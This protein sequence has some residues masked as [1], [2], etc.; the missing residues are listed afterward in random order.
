M[1]IEITPI[2]N[3]IPLLL[4]T[5][6]NKIEEGRKLDHSIDIKDTNGQQIKKSLNER[7]ENLNKSSIK[8]ATTIFKVTVGLSESNPDAYKPKLLSI[9]PYHKHDSKLGS[10]ENYKLC[11]LQRFLKRN[12]GFHDVESCISEMDKLKDDA[13]K[14]YDDIGGLIDICNIVEIFSE[15]LLLDGCFVVEFIREQCKIIPTGEDMIIMRDCIRNQLKRDLLLVENQLPWFVLTKLY[16][17]SKEENEKPFIAMVNRTFSLAKSS[18][19][20]KD[21][22]E[23]VKHLFHVVHMFMSFGPSKKIIPSEFRNIPTIR[24]LCGGWRGG[25]KDED[26]MWHKIM[27]NATELFE[28]GVSFANVGNIFMRSLEK[29]K[30][31]NLKDNTCLFDIKFN[32]G[33]MTIPC[34][35]VVD[36]TE[37]LMRNLI[38]YEQ[39]SSDVQQRYFSDF[40]VFMDYL[41]DSDKDVSLLCMNGI[42]VNKLGEDKQVASFFNKIGKGIAVSEDFYYEEECRK[43]VQHCEKPCNRIGANFRHNYFNTP[44]A[45]ISTLAAIILL[46]LTATQTVLAFISLFK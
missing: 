36:E 22:E 35:Q 2:D 1:S 39:Q 38:A 23:N 34:F 7:I 8:S 18:I 46:L 5:G 20:T 28:A 12:G 14:C 42:I 11:Y 32:N 10:M 6:K 13:F 43:A 3:Q 30:D 40:A 9:G 15:M 4:S 29:V 17:I 16:E 27:P 41:I 45:G 24:S 37:T 31:N 21:I 26:M 33:L 25:F 44:W 19:K